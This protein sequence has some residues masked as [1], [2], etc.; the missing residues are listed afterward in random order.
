MLSE[1]IPSWLPV[2]FSPLQNLIGKNV[3]S[4]WKPVTLFA[5]VLLAVGIIAFLTPLGV[6]EIPAQAIALWGIVAAGYTAARVTPKIGAINAGIIAIGVLVL[7]LAGVTA[8]AQVDPTTAAGAAE[9]TANVWLLWLFGW[10][11]GNLGRLFK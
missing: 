8:Y 7:A 10:L 11:G 2:L 5:F 6:D 3:P 9:Q 1:Y 4:Q